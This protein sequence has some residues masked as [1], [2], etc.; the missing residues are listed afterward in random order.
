MSESSLGIANYTS[1]ISKYTGNTNIVRLYSNDVHPSI[2]NVIEQ[3]VEVS[4]GGYTHLE[5]PGSEC[6]VSS[7][8]EQIE[9]VFPAKIF[10]FDGTTTGNGEVVGYYVTNNP[11]TEILLCVRFTEAYR[12]ELGGICAVRPR[13]RIS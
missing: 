4:G 6:V 10:T 9:L 11:G 5:L 13:I 2:H 7:D 12:P 1:L 8:G 3:F